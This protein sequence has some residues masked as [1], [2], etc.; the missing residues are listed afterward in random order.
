MHSYG[1]AHGLKGK[2]ETVGVWDPTPELAAKFSD[3]FDMPVQASLDGLLAECDAVIITSEN[4]RHL[5]ITEQVAAAGKPMLCEK[6]IVTNHAEATALR[7]LVARGAKIMTAFPCRYSPAFKALQAKVAAGEIGAIRAICATNR[8]T[9]PGGWFIDPALSGGGAMIDHVVHVTDLLRVLMKSEV[10]RVQAQTGNQMYGQ[11]WEDTAMLTLDF[12]NGVFATLDSSWS[13]HSTYKIWGDV[14]M[15]VV[16]DG[17]VIEIDLF[18]QVF[19]V[20][21]EPKHVN[22]GYGSDIDAGLVADFIR[23]ATE[24]GE[25][26]ISAEDGIRAVEV[27]LAGYRSARESE[28]VEVT[29]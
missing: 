13:R 8:G 12:E 24:G 5:G 14:T 26:P 20:Y 4:T 22:A 23:F 11:E 27:A 17:G 21:R 15:N 2:A 1:Y 25:P 3:S 6:P 29:A 16:G 9:N 10:A 28:A 18:G 7:A 19:D